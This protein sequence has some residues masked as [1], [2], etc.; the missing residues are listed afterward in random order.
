MEFNVWDVYNLI[1]WRDFVIAPIVIILIY[2]YV[3]FYL[4]R[5]KY[6]HS[7]LKKYL[8][9][10][11]TVRIIGCILSALMYDYYYK[12]GDTFGYYEGVGV[13]YRAF[14]YD[15]STAL[16]MIFNDPSNYTFEIQNLI[17]TSTAHASWYFESSSSAM[18]I[19][20]GGLLSI[21]TF[22][23]YLS[24]GLILSFF[25]Y[26]GC[27]KILKVFSRL[28]PALTKPI[29][30]ATLFV[31][32]IFFWGAAG[33]MK[34]TLCMASIGFLV[35]GSYLFF[36][37]RKKII[38]SI[39]KIGISLYIIVTVKIY[40]A[41]AFVPALVIWVFLSYNAGIKSKI[42]RV[43]A[44][45][46]FTTVIVMFSIVAFQLLGQLTTKY[47]STEVIL[48]TA[49]ITQDAVFRTGGSSY[50]LGD[51]DPNPMGILKMAPKSINVTLFRPYPWEVLSKPILLPNMLESI[52]TLFL[53]IYVFFSVGVF[54]SLKI[55]YRDP[56][57]IFC[58]IFALVF[59][60]AVGFSTF[61]FGALARYKIPCLPFYFIL[62]GVI[63]H[64]G[65]MLKTKKVRIIKNR[66]ANLDESYT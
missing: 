26:L 61:N 4:K 10:G 52:F 38:S 9:P 18:V 56:N 48:K 2:G 44:L 42:I 51:W 55:I 22:N 60:F 57:L 34:D 14:F 32:S 35:E 66:L 54:K 17:R 15:P 23:S 58:L 39:L 31:P 49:K 7:I 25:S 64:K 24:I 19:R 30:Y 11:L 3:V 12:A 43:A 1:G 46:I 5:K 41:I 16:E 33:L 8:V 6:K 40:I 59:A 53:T 13:I 62:L 65:K 20:I 45:P 63:L 50:H 28:Y 21:F 36:I 29:A 37:R 47:Q 27:W